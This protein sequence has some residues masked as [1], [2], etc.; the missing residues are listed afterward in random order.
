MVPTSDVGTVL[1]FLPIPSLTKKAEQTFAP[2]ALSSQEIHHMQ[3]VTLGNPVHQTFRYFRIPEM[4]RSQLYPGGKHTN[5]PFFQDHALYKLVKG[6][7]DNEWGMI[8]YVYFKIKFL[9]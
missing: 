2:Q 4:P 3:I 5:S 9:W 6:E 7:F 8:Q 1:Y